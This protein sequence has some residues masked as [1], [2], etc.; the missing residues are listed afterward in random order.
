MAQAWQTH[1][2]AGGASV[3]AAAA[4]Q[5]AGSAW[6]QAGSRRRSSGVSG[7]PGRCQA[8]LLSSRA[9]GIPGDRPCYR[10]AK[11]QAL[12]GLAFLPAAPA[13]GAAGRHDTL[14]FRGMARAWAGDPAGVADDM[15]T[16]VA[17]LVR[18]SRCAT[19]AGA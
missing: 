5:L 14:V 18:L 12:A 11:T 17:R 19:P 6:W 10:W 3:G 4:T 13:R 9:E 2:P 8:R 1:D 16:A 7:G 15:A